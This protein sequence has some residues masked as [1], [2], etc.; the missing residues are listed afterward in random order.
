MVEVKVKRLR[1]SAV[2]PSYA[3]AG[4][5]GMDI[6]SDENFVLGPNMRHTFS[7]GI[8]MAFP[9]GY[10]ALVWDKSGLASKKGVTVLGGVI[11]AGYRGE[12]KVVLYNTTEDDFEVRKGDKLAQILLQKIER[13]EVREVSEL[14][15]TTRGEGGFGSTGR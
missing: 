14:E 12:Y 11:D 7:T 3:H 5:A 8:S 10:V 4:D 15:E 6:Y 1:E 13:G 9:E 2:L